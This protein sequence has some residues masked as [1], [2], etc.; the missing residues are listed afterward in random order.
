MLVERS[1]EFD[2]LQASFVDCQG[3]KGRVVLVTGGP[4][5]G[6]TE[7]LHVI[8]EH[9]ADSGA[10]LL[11]AAGA[12]A[13]KTLWMG[14]VDQLLGSARSLAQASDQRAS[15]RTSAGETLEEDASGSVMS[16]R[17]AR[18]AQEVHSMVLELAA[19]Q[20]V[21]IVVDDIQ[22]ADSSSMHV[23]AYIIRRMRSARVL[24]VLT[25][26]SRPHLSW[27]WFRAEL[28]RSRYQLIK[29]A[30]L[31][32]QGVE[33]LMR[34]RLA[35]EAAAHAT[36][37]HE[38]SGGNPLLVHALIDDHRSNGGVVT[39]DEGRL[40][41]GPAFRHAVLACL[42]HCLDLLDVARAVA[43]LGADASPKLVALLMGVDPE[44]V[45]QALDA[46]TEA[47]LFNGDSFRQPVA[48]AALLD[49]VA[50]ATC[51]RMHHRAAELLHQHGASSGV[52]ANHL[53]AAKEPY[54]PWAFHALKDAADEALAVDDTDLAVRL[55]TAALRGCADDRERVSVTTALARV[56]SRVNP[57]AAALRLESLGDAL[58]DGD[59]SGRDAVT[60]VRHLLWQG[61]LEQL[62]KVLTRLRSSWG[63]ADAQIEAEI[64]I[65]CQGVFGTLCG[66][67]GQGGAQDRATR[68]STRP[69]GNPW[70]QAA[71]T[72]TAGFYGGIT[73]EVVNNA[74]YLLDSGTVGDSS[75][76]MLAT[77]LFT[78]TYADELDCATT[79]C[80][81][82]LGQAVRRQAPAWQAIL[83]SVHADI[84]FRQGDLKTADARARAA[85]ELLPAQAWGVFAGLPLSTLVLANSAMGN[86]GAAEEVLRQTVPSSMF[87]TVFGLRYL[88]ARGEHWLQTGRL[89]SAYS[90]FHMCGTLMAQWNMD[91]PP[92]VPWRS[93]LAEV[94][95]RLGCDKTAR[96]LVTEQLGRTGALST[97]TRGLS[98]IVLASSSDLRKRPG[99]LREAVDLLQKC[100]DGLG[101]ARALAD[102]SQVHHE[103]GDFGRAR[104][105]AHRAGQHAKACHADLIMAQL[106]RSGV[107]GHDEPL[108]E[109]AGAVPLLS[110]AECRVATLAALGH[111]NREIGE[112]LY[113]TPSTV[114]Q[115]LTRVYRKLNVEGRKN[116]PA[117]LSVN[118]LADPVTEGA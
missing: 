21:V 70:T 29:L 35:D 77:A 57:A 60:V 109:Q 96:D 104:M 71:S 118:L 50:P 87:Q 2:R 1:D 99:L 90:D 92:V 108:D 111:T 84:A 49:S 76:E 105:L 40:R 81:V 52:V 17:D 62:T 12:S 75:L 10:L 115:H 41:V 7:L 47:G 113:V 82:L 73:E 28:T 83:G 89:L 65:A 4:A 103:L 43:I 51:A 48:E 26:W 22:F 6:K 19:V 69:S 44:F 68:I 8:S 18:V 91:A 33:E 97:R 61:K 110:E 102:L 117:K 98:L 9:V 20:P 58:F 34:G 37:V 24:V 5:S 54:A 3:G 101:L 16:M 31:S 14:V 106:V 79:W 114:E 63:P 59:L 27:P 46:F 45:S 94:H 72:L 66:S 93:K 25:E 30:P 112:R 116:L 55:L 42:Y 100:G 67:M 53:L 11:S 85:L 95:V 74:Q 15:S 86:F 78:L 32:P 36:A 56:E 80:E 23:L 64:E 107:F 88:H 38:A 39:D 13:E